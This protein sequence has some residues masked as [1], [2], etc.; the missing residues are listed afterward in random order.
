MRQDPIDRLLRPLDRFIKGHSTAGMALFVS[1]AVAVVLANSPWR[2]AY[3]AIWEH[4]FAI[5]V[6]DFYF[7]L[8]LHH[9]INDGLMAMFFFLVALELKREFIAG[10]MTDRKKAMLPVAASVGGMLAPALIYLAVNQF[11]APATRGWGI[12]LGTDTAFVLALLALLGKRVPP[13]IKALFITVSVID[14]IVSVSVIALFYTSDLS[15]ANLGIGAAFLAVLVLMNLLGVRNM[16]AYAVVGIGG[17][18]MAFML[19]G[20]H[21]TVAGVLAAMAI[22]ATTKVKE[23]TYVKKIRELADE[24]ERTED[25]P[26]RTIT[27]EQAHIIEKVKRCSLNAETPL[28]RLEHRLHPWVSFLVLPLFALANAGIEL[29]HDMSALAS[30]VT[31]GVFLGLVLGKPLGIFTTCWLFVKMGWGKLGAGVQWGHMLAI[32]VISGLGFTMALFISELA[33]DAGWM[34]ADAK[35]GILLASVTAGIAGTFLFFRARPGMHP[36]G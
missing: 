20:V 19:S 17:V 3:R 24:F 11:Q 21:A 8:N 30:P 7:G 14:D 12:T 13:A 4:S 10:D 26:H 15:L 35:L 2:E 23:R 25:S 9:L 33:F 18:W 31:M 22:P 32:S 6:D 16:T 1:A 28:Q 29:P 5:Q 36:A 34:R 27:V